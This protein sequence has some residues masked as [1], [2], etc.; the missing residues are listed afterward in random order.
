MT[1]LIG[2][3]SLYQASRLKP[4]NDNKRHRATNEEME[5]RAQFLIAYAAKNFP[6]T[7]RQLF[8]AATVASIPG[9]SKDDNG[10]CAIQQQVLKLRRAGRMPYG[11]IA[12]MTRMRRKP[13]TYGGVE[14]ALEETARFYRKALWRDQPA[15]VEVWVEKDAL[16]GCLLP[17]TSRFDVPLMV[18]RGFT[19]ETFAYE[20]VEEWEEIGKDEVHVYHLGDFD[21][22]GQDAAKDLRD[23][24]NR[25]AR[26]R[27]VRFFF[28]RLAVTESQVEYF[29][30]PTREPKRNTTADK[31]WPYDYACELDAIPPDK[32]RTMLWNVLDNYI[33]HDQMKVLEA[34]EESERTLLKGLAGMAA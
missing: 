30:L 10:Y 11:H 29:N 28:E 18:C 9:I 16:A 19:S 33:P 34:A 26:D 24:L 15:H 12:D 1:D 2:H 27:D 17:V 3:N 14:E 23:K 6:V 32:L 22:S 8:Y 4:D 31:R 20:A 21:R 25:F 7:V 13:S 5:V